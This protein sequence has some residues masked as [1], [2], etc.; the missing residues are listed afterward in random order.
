[1]HSANDETSASF[2]RGADEGVRAPSVQYLIVNR[3]RAI[4]F[5]T[6]F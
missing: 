2:A 6:L 3:A 5:G 4:Q 1:L